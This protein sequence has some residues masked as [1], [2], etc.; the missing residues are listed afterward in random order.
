MSIQ[1]ARPTVNGFGILRS[2]LEEARA[3]IKCSLGDLTVLS[4]A[5]DP[6][7]LDTPANHRNGQWL[8]KQLDRLVKSGKRIHWRGVHYALVTAAPRKPDGQ[9]YRNTDEDWNWLVDVAGK[10]ARWLGYIP[11]DR[12]SDNRNSA[13]VI[14]RKARVAPQAFVS[15]GINVAIPDVEDLHPQPLAQG[16][17]ARQAFSF[18]VFGEKAS[19]ED[20]VT[21]IARAHQADAYF[22]TGE[23]SDTYVYQI[24]EDADA[25]GRPLVVFALS[26]CDPAGHQMPVSIGRK[27]QAF[28]DLMFP[29]L[30]FEIVP[31][32]LTVDQV[33]DLGLPS[34]PL[35]ETERRAD[36]WRQA[37]GIEQTEVDALATLQPDVLREIVERAFDPYVDRDLKARVA[38]AE[39]DWLRQAEEA[40]AEQSDPVILGQLREEASERLAELESV[41]ADINERLRLAADDFTLPIIEV[42][43]PELDTDVV[44]RALVTFDQSWIEATRALIRRKAYEAEHG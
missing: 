24:A 44:R 30:Q 39:A 7:R 5:V 34:T 31:V 1:S 15:V 37:F 8:A 42:P 21:P 16:F 6:Y 12:I 4:A 13:P 27:L 20:G 26:D 41:I 9:I 22:M 23:I 29:D 10:A 36:R 17:D 18:V 25:D 11:F 14:H 32:A 28:R 40:I 2:V 35:K 3:E 38:Q 19:L 43:E 33:R